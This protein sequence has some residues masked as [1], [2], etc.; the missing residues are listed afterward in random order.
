MLYG[1][2][3]MQ[4]LKGATDDIRRKKGDTMKIILLLGIRTHKNSSIMSKM[5]V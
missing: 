5:L 1:V 2:D 4:K 3:F